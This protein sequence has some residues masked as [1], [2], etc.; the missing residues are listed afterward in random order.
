[1]K[2]KDPNDEEFN[3]EEQD[4][5]NEADDSF[6][7]P[8]LDFNTLE[9]EETSAGEQEVDATPEE[10]PVAEETTNIESEAEISEEE[11]ETVTE[12]ENIASDEELEAVAVEEE[13]ITTDDDESADS[14]YV[15]PKPESNASKIII[16]L[17]VTIVVAIGAWYLLFYRPQAAAEAEKVRVEAQK[18]K[19]IAAK[20]AAET[21]RLAD[22]AAAAQAAKAAKQVEEENPKEGTFTTISERTGRYYVVILS[23]LDADKA[24]DFGKELAAKGVSTALISPSDKK[25]FSRLTIGDYGSFVE[26]QEAAN[27]LKGEYGE[28]LWV[29]K[30]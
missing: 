15:P 21:K 9:E 8:D 23:N 12:E 13:I 22:E 3:Q 18:Q 11:E 19:D 16:A 27:K 29:L 24:S 25:T 10:E 6:G 5:I 30:Y 1:M 2:D 17:L 20:K 26:A 4:N 14:T 28:D 7:L